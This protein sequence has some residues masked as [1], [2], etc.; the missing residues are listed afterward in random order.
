MIKHFILIGL[1]FLLLSFQLKTEK[2]E[3]DVLIVGGG[4]S[5]ISA[6]I[7]SA[8]L[9][10]STLILE[11]YS[12][13]GGMLT[14]AGVSAIDGNYKLPSGFWGEFRD[15]L[16]VHYGGVQDL[17]TGWV[18]KVLFEPSV[19]NKILNT[20]AAKEEFLDVKFN[21]YVSNITK[22]KGLWSVTYRDIKGKKHTVKCK[23]LIDG[24]ELGDVAKLCN[25]SY[26]V[27][28]ESHKI[29]GE[30]IAPENSN[31]IIQDLTYVAILKDYGKDVK[32]EKP[33]SY[34]P[35]LFACCCSNPL[36][37]NPKEPD[38]LWSQERLLNYGRL[39]NNKFMINW[40]LEGN[41]YYLNLIDVDVADR[42]ELLKEAKEQTMNFVYFM[43]HELGF[44]TIG[45]ADDEYPTADKLPFIPYHRESRRI[46]GLVRFQLEHITDPYTQNQLLYRTNIAVG[47]YPVDHHHAR[48]QGAEELP[49]LY[50]HAIPS[51]G[52]PMGVMLP[53]EVDDL[54]VAEK[55][56]SVSNIVNGTT[57]LQ[58][59]VLQIG[60]AAGT[61][62]AIAVKKKC[63]LKD[64][65]VREV[66]SQL[67]SNGVYLMPFLDVNKTE[68]MFLPLQRIG[69][70]GM[71]RAEGKTV[72]W[73]NE[74]WMRIADVLK[75]NELEGLLD[76]YPYLSKH[77]DLTS[78]QEMHLDTFLSLIN[79]IISEESI[80][81]DTSIESVTN[82]YHEFS[83][84]S[85]Q[86]NSSMT[87]GEAI[88]L[89]DQWLDPFNRVDVGI[90][91]KLLNK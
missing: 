20:I 16:A 87:R 80:N 15:S 71:L 59:V 13:L 69:A 82:L 44:N 35:S 63:N 47:D 70:T 32:I 38:R 30:D 89:L 26:D 54:I 33:V 83:L 19:G 85:P 14:S 88:L 27:G 9:G 86:L 52:L 45:L 62:A 57:R 25:V 58:P 60:Q 23:I 37:V 3:V 90:T 67:L 76:Y 22:K 5:G 43:Q 66:Q 48:Y 50:F 8:R 28:M 40:P 10:V 56:I 77:L 81:V 74:T 2:T 64:I 12:W 18:S 21:T 53:K 55:S 29:T 7:S 84:S 4:T 42:D 36:C 51:F 75:Q 65:S 78:T 49:N 73:S 39:P 24:T 34:D 17:S 6:G 31:H 61:L 91:G 1:F 72:G 46:H 11:E 68:K 41:D 79:I